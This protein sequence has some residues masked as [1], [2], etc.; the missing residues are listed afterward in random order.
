MIGLW[1]AKDDA[2]PADGDADGAEPATGPTSGTVHVNVPVKVV[3][4]RKV[5]KG[6]QTQRLVYGVVLEPGVEDTQ[7]D[8]CSAAE[9]EKAAHGY[10]M[11]AVR[12]RATVHKLQHRLRAFTK[13][14]PQLVPVESFVAPCDFRYEG[15]D[16][17]I[18]KGS[19]V[20]VAK[21]LD[22]GVWEAVEK[23]LFS[24]WSM[25]GTG[26]RHAI[27]KSDTAT[28]AGIA[29]RASDTGRVLM[30]QR[31]LD[32][33]NH[34][35]A[36]R[37]ELPGGK[38]NPGETPQ[39]GAVREWQEETGTTLPPGGFAGSWR[40]GVYEGFV[41]VV[42]RESDVV[43]NRDGDDRL[44]MNPDDPDG[45]GAEVAAWWNPSDLPG[46]P[47]LRDECQGTDWVLIGAAVP[48]PVAK[49]ASDATASAARSAAA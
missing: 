31:S 9:I 49:R 30:L 14:N 8:I 2:A 29:V 1:I 11:K 41:Y 23:G 42:E 27:A 5:E 38:L 20:L 32:D 22:D 26:R 18:R 13:D 39:Q 21:V 43:I 6:Q 19:W 45:D 48:Q 34:D 28:V 25:G 16:D 33:D 17:L 46:M 24:G 40:S 47:A 12:G 44:V 15:S 37:W 4:R 7:G 35:A 10:V 3:G 36:G